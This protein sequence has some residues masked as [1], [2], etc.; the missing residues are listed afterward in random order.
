MHRVARRGVV[1]LERQVGRGRQP[2]AGAAKANAR[3]SEAPQVGPRRSG[4]GPVVMRPA[5][6]MEG[7]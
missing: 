7:T 6:A 4:S 1:G 5:I 3:R 2:V